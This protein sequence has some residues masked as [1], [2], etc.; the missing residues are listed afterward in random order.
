[1]TNRNRGERGI[2]ISVIQLAFLSTLYFCVPGPVLTD[3]YALFDAQIA[4][5]T[6]PRGR[7]EL[8]K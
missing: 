5:L 7:L 3:T 1:M 8:R 4:E 6:E 2:F